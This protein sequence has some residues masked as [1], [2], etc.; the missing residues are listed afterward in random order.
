MKGSL[1]IKI[2]RGLNFTDL[3]TP[4]LTAFATVLRSAPHTAAA[5]DLEIVGLSRAFSSSRVNL[6]LRSFRYWYV[7]YSS[8]NK[9]I[10][11]QSCQ[12]P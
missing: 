2:L 7:S 8:T 12:V 5:M 9:N 4:D 3:M 6:V 11:D 10:L 1:R